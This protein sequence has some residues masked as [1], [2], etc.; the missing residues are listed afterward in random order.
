MTPAQIN[1]HGRKLYGKAWE[2]REGKESMAA[3]LCRSPS[4]IYEWLAG[5]SQMP[6]TAQKKLKQLAQQQDARP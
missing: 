3:D 4:T 5:T 1:K 2:G 6:E